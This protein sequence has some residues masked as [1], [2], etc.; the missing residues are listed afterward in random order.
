MT[1]LSLLDDSLMIAWQSFCK[2]S[3]GNKSEI[4]MFQSSSQILSKSYVKPNFPWKPTF[5]IGD[6]AKSCFS[7]TN[8]LAQE[9]HEFLVPNCSSKVCLRKFGFIHQHWNTFYDPKQ[10]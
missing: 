2:K 9:I 5:E 1:A 7:S 8:G 3:M 6:C 4:Y 10:C